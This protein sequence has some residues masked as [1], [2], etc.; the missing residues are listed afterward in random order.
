M[1]CCSSSMSKAGAFGEEIS[2]CP[3]AAVF[4]ICM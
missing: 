4:I 2:T 1:L 3:I